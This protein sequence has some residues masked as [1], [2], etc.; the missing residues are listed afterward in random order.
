[1]FCCS[2]DEASGWRRFLSDRTG[3]NGYNAGEYTGTGQGNNGEIKV[4]VTFSDTAIESVEVV[5]H[6]E[7]AGICEPAMEE[8]PRRS[9]THRPIMWTQ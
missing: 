4:K 1:M 5:E 8:I 3:A 6:S 9:L 2:G 7:S